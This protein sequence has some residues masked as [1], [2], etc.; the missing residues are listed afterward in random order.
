VKK[1]LKYRSQA[2]QRFSKLITTELIK[3]ISHTSQLKAEKMSLSNQ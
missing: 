2:I 3:R 1:G